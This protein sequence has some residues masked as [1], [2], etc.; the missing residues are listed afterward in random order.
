MVDKKIGVQDSNTSL[1]QALLAANDISPD[2]L[3]IVPV[4]YDPSVL[5]NGEVD[6]F[7]AYLTILRPAV[8]PRP[9]ARAPRRGRSSGRDSRP[10]RGAH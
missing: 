2:D 7:V 1:F 9:A 3:T 4:Q 6:G 8:Q 10:G 5:V